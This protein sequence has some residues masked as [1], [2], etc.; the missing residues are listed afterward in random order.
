[1]K[2]ILYVVIVSLFVQLGLTAQT[3]SLRL[4]REGDKAFVIHKVLAKQ[5][6]FSLARRYQTSVGAINDTN[7]FLKSGLQIGQTLK[8]PYGGALPS[9]KPE[10]VSNTQTQTHVVSAGETLFSIAR[11]YEVSVSDLKAWNGLQSNGL[12]LDQKLVIK[13]EIAA[14]APSEEALEVVVTE[15]A[16]VTEEAPQTKDTVAV[17]EE[18][19]TYDGTPFQQRVYEGVAEVIEEDEPSSKFFALHKTAKEGT[20]IKVRNVMNDITVY[21]RVIGTIP[22]VGSNEDLII[23]INQRAYES[24]K[25]IDKRFRVEISYFQ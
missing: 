9:E 8:I 11:K 15:A 13:K 7:P 5:T 21:V 10:L 14:E 6:L 18:K 4:E 2:R 3:D 25:A 1:M 23:K 17:E 12:A 24:L 16:V 22:E 20:V 19:I